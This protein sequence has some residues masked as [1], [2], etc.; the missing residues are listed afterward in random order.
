[1]RLTLKSKLLL[2]FWLGDVVASAPS[3]TLT[4]GWAAQLVHIGIPDQP[5]AG[6]G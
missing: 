4:E 1:M 5:W 3:W 2:N 6:G